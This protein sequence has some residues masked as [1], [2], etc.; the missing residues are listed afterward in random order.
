MLGIK[1]KRMGILQ[2]KENL[3]AVLVR[4]FATP[5]TIYF[6]TTTTAQEKGKNGYLMRLTQLQR[7]HHHIY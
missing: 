2:C 3:N 1:A 6:L 7:N 5:L 4:N